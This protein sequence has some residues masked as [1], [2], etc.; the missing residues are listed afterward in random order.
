[1]TTEPEEVIIHKGQHTNT[2]SSSSLWMRLDLPDNLPDT[3]FYYNGPLSPYCGQVTSVVQ[4]RVIFYLLDSRGHPL[5]EKRVLRAEEDVTVVNKQVPVEQFGVHGV[6]TNGTE[7]RVGAYGPRGRITCLLTARDRLGVLGSDLPLE[8]LI[9][10]DSSKTLR[11]VSLTLYKELTFRGSYSGNRIH[12]VQREKLVKIRLPRVEP[13]NVWHREITH[14]PIPEDCLTSASLCLCSFVTLRFFVRV[15]VRWWW[16]GS[17][18]CPVE[19]FLG[20]EARRRFT[21]PDSGVIQYNV[22]GL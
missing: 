18:E 12:C 10:N 7:A 2:A 1:M 17:L 4:A 19:V 14:F 16:G 22:R 11:K 6:G 21:P 15:K 9:R 20:T 5:G 13:H 8:V 3:W